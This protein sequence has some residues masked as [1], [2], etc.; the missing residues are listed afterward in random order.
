MYKS[1]GKPY[2][3]AICGY[4]THIE[5]AHIKAVSDFEDSA[6]IAEINSIDNLIALCPNHHWEYDNGILKLN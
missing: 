1:S 6:T 5:I 3:C 2:C 4:S